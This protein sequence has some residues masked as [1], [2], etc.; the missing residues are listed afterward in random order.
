M[1][2]QES[3]AEVCQKGCTWARISKS[4]PSILIQLYKAQQLQQFLCYSH[5]HAMSRTMPVTHPGNILTGMNTQCWGE[6]IPRHCNS[7]TQPLLSEG[8]ACLPS[9]QTQRH[10]LY[11]SRASVVKSARIRAQE[12]MNE[13]KNFLSLKMLPWNMAKSTLHPWMRQFCL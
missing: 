2:F 9:N 10:K 12:F 1:H 7:S 11:L 8:H 5:S 6:M 13:N 4:Y 3:S